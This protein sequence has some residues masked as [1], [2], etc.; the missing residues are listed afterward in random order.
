[1]SELLRVTAATRQALINKSRSVTKGKQRFY[2]RL[3][4]T[5]SYPNQALAGIN[6][7]KW[8]KTDI[9][10]AKISVKGET[11]HYAVDISFWG[12]WNSYAGELTA[13]NVKQ[14]ITRA[15]RTEDVY[16]RCSC[17]DFRYRMAYS[18]TQGGYIA[19]TPEYR[20]A[21]IT[22]PQDNLGSACKH[23]LLCLMQSGRW[24]DELS[25]KVVKYVSY[26]KRT[27]TRLYDKFFKDIFEEESSYSEIE[28][29][30]VNAPVVERSPSGKG[31]NTPIGDELAVL[32][33]IIDEGDGIE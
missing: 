1:M 5:I 22:N 17:P 11:D 26:I 15:F 27:N 18:A 8:I 20:P 23:V 6:I 30:I 2:R 9:L 4:S 25:R 21:K 16:I 28:E 31:Q 7:D 33:E 3:F 12:A 14:A 19:H 29:D 13:Y 10:D 32:E 24:I